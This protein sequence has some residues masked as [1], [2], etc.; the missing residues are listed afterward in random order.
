[1]RQKNI[2][3][4]LLIAAVFI[5]GQTPTNAGVS[6]PNLWPTRT[7]NFVICTDADPERGGPKKCDG[8]LR[9][10]QTMAQ[11]VREGVELWNRD[12]ADHIRFV[13]AA[14]NQRDTVMVAA[15]AKQTSCGVNKV[16]YTRGQKTVM[17]LGSN[18]ASTELTRHGTILHEF[19]HVAGL[20]HEQRRPDRDTYLVLDAALLR[21]WV[22]AGRDG[23]EAAF[24][25]T[26]L[27]DVNDPGPCTSDFDPIFGGA[28]SSFGARHGRSRG[29]Y[30]FASVMHYSLQPPSRQG[31]AVGLTGAGLARLAEQQREGLPIG[32]RTRLSEGDLA[33][34]RAMYP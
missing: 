24:Q 22:G 3:L 21:Q 31:P 28:Y 11:R 27:C 17:K 4:S 32:Q 29:A 19:G 20:Q 1:M 26:R 14:D 18:C 12:L 25:Y 10:S 23:W 5:V 34:I 6:D 8:H 7:I 9:L 33:A 30:D 16:G 15:S 13:E 2:L